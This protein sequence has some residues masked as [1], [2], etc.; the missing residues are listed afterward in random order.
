[1]ANSTRPVLSD[2]LNRAETEG[3][4]HYSRALAPRSPGSGEGTLATA[5]PGP[6]AGALKSAGQGR[7]SSASG[8]LHE[9][10]AGLVQGRS[11]R[12]PHQAGRE[13]WL[14]QRVAEERWTGHVR[15]QANGTRVLGSGGLG[16]VTPHVTRG[17]PRPLRSQS[18]PPR[19]EA[20]RGGA[21]DPGICTRGLPPSEPRSGGGSSGFAGS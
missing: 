15:A 20:R 18:A 17:R 16:V 12:G 10:V 5:G 6:S 3:I 8:S 1:M 19:R 14:L 7:P 9:R 11:R 13:P 21:G 4:S 2:T